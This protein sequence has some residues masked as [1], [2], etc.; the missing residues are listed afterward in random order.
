MWIVILFAL[1][2]LSPAA[3]SAEEAPVERPTLFVY[4]DYV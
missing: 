1:A 4:S 2:M 3:A